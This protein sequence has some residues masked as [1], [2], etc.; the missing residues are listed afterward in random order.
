MNKLRLKESFEITE[1]QQLTGL[2]FST[3]QDKIDKGIQL[4]LLT[5]ISDGKYQPTAKGLQF[6]NDLVDLFL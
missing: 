3:V 5:Q 6:Y 1:F 2:D 4:T